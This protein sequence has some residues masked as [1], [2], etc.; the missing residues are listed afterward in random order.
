MKKVHKRIFLISVSILAM[1][2][3]LVLVFDVLFHAIMKY[4]SYR[5]KKSAVAMFFCNSLCPMA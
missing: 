4:N 3:V 5:N 2:L 1:I